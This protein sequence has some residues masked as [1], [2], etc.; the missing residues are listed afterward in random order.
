MLPSMLGALDASRALTAREDVRTLPVGWMHRWIS[1]RGAR[2]VL[3]RGRERGRGGRPRGREHRAS[4]A[5]GARGSRLRASCSR[6][7]ATCSPTRTSRRARTS[8]SSGF[9]DGT[10]SRARRRGARSRD[11]PRRRARGAAR[12]RARRASAALRRSR[13][14]SSSSP[15]ATRWASA[16]PCR[17]ASSA[18]LGS[19]HACARRPRHGR[20]H[21]ERRRPQPRQQRRPAGRL[22]RARRRRQHGHHPR[23]AGHQ[24]QRPDR[25]GQVGR[26][27]AHDARPRAARVA[28]HRGA[29]PPLARRTS[30]AV[31]VSI[32]RAASRS[33]ASTSAARPATAT[34]ARATSSSA[35]TSGRVAS[36]DDLHRALQKWP[37]AGPLRLKVVREAH[38]VDVDV[39]AVEAPA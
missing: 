12:A 34:C 16:R 5:A 38:L 13:W 10:T 18:P 20:D 1:T 25:H 35:S 3:A 37:I 31:S 22:A 36:V 30:R 19:H 26:G 23:R 2:R 17:R 28:R 4:L 14:D 24:L 15:S 6:P 21:P 11:R 9:T 33:A 39:Q 7:T 32:T 8:S 27:R 29:E